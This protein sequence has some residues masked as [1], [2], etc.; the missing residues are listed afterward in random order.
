MSLFF[1]TRTKVEQLPALHRD[2]VL[3]KR[4]GVMQDRRG[5]L[6]F[7]TSL[8]HHDE[9]TGG[10]RK[11]AISA[12]FL[13]V[14]LPL[15]HVLMADAAPDA[16]IGLAF[17]EQDVPLGPATKLGTVV[18]NGRQRRGMTEK[19]G[20]DTPLQAET[21]LRDG[22]RLLMREDR[23]R[24]HR[25]W[26]QTSSSGKTK[27]KSRD[28]DIYRYSV[29]LDLPKGVT[30]VNPGVRGSWPCEIEDRG[31]R[32]RV[33]VRASTPTRQDLTVVLDLITEALRHSPST[34]MSEATS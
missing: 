30:P 28:K 9:V 24:R 19:W 11:Y 22:S 16:R 29:T 21:M 31:S 4:I 10:R 27:W 5:W 23:R 12:R 8:S 15:L 32:F 2:L 20:S 13:D 14:A 18:V 17:V 26:R 3:S 1:P 34:H 33:R 7:L 25:E 6:D